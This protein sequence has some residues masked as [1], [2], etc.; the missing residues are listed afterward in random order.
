MAKS[1]RADKDL[2]RTI[3]DRYKIMAD[4]DSENRKLAMADMKFVNVPGM[5]WDDNMKLERGNRPCYEFNKLRVSGKRI[6]NEMRSNRPQGKVRG[7][8]DGDVETAEIYEGLIRNI[9][10]VSDGDTVIDYAGEYQVNGGMGAWRINT[11]YSDDTAFDQDIVIEP[12]KNP[13]CLY[14]D[15]AA[16]DALKRDAEDWILTEKISKKAFETKYKNAKRLSFDDTEFDDNEDWEDDNSVRVAEYWFKEP[17]D[18][19]IWLV[20]DMAIDSTSPEAASIPPEAITRTRTVRCHKIMMC[21]VGGGDAILEGPVEWAGSEFPFVMIF[22]EYIVIDGKTY[23]WGLPRFGKDAQRSYNVAGTAVIETIAMAPK[24]FDWAT[25]DNAKGHVEK[26]LEAHQ[27]NYPFKLYNPD[28]KNGGAPPARVGGADIPIALIQQM[29]IASQDIRDVLGIHEASFGEEGNE[30]SGIALRSKQNQAAMVTYNFPDN[31]AKGVRRTWEI[32]IDLIPKVYD[33]QR[34]VRILGKDG[35][36]SYEKINER[37]QDAQGNATVLN[38]LQVGKFDVTVT[39]G[40]SYA[41]QRQEAAETLTQM[42]QA[43]EALMPT[44][45]DLVYKSM[46]IP[47]ADEIAERRRLMLP[48]PIQKML[49]EGKKMPPEVAAAQAQVDRAME[50]VQQQTQLVQAAIEEIKD[51]QAKAEKAKSEVKGLISD[52][53]VKRAQFDA[54]IATKMAALTVKEAGIQQREGQIQGQ[55]DQADKAV[56]EV[57]EAQKAVSEIDGMVSQFMEASADVLKQINDAMGELKARPKVKAIH[58]QR[59]PGQ[60]PK[61]VPEYEEATPA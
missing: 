50:V 17:Y 18:K 23:W 12:I 45:A 21:I 22:G 2:I 30:K 19:E 56:G 29:E 20:G 13:F 44:S 31:M 34:S 41:T 53:D 46:D 25:A 38:D 28:P 58:I 14:A 42:A 40:P 1:K 5:Q 10:N 16:Q 7:V 32:L 60:P 48:A 47:Y 3:R 57:S 33:T 36:E 51:D 4:A 54:D 27:K 52:L 59:E 6:I 35:A 11:E 24:A 15:P 61:A 37:T 43:D 8:E 9:W 49:T 26:W 55:Q 39:I